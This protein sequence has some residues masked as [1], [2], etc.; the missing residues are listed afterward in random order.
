MEKNI[1]FIPIVLAVLGL[2]FMLVKMS[3]VKKTSSWKR[4]HAVYI[5]KH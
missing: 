3:W 1:I 5:K 2:L 4:P